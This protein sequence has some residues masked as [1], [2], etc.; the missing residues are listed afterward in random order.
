M[1]ITVIIYVSF[2]KI[3]ERTFLTENKRVSVRLVSFEASLSSFSR[4]GNSRISWKTNSLFT[5]HYR[6]PWERSGRWCGDYFS[7]M[8]C[9][10]VAF[11][12]IK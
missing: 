11:K 5:L 7:V 1:N 2:Q 6:V 8:L 10:G 9:F 12:M 4:V 3:V